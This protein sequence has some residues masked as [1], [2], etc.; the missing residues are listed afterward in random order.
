M[1]RPRVLLA[2]DHA[3][4]LGVLERLLE[5]EYETVGKVSDGRALVVRAIALAPDA[6]V[7]D[8]SMPELNG[9]EATRQILAQLPQVRI[10]ILTVHRDAALAAEALRAGAAGYVLK[11]SAVSELRRALRDVL[12]G[13]T[14]LTALVADGDA[15]PLAPSKPD[16]SKAS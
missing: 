2:D 5:E 9:L 11:Q 14:Y 16:P 8:I 10:V 1:T 4:V 3:L 7:T 13:M 15:V 6:V 12:C